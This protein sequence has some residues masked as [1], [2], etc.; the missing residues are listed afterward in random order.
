MDEELMK[1][2]QKIY[3]VNETKVDDNSGRMSC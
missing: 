1:S 3:G 2:T